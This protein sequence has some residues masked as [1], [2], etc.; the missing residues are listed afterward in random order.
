MEKI[1]VLF[2][3]LGNICRS[4]AA[5]GTFRHLVEEQGLADRFE[6]DS[7]GTGAYH[8]G[9]PPNANSRRAASRRGIQLGGRARQFKSRDFE[10]FEYIFT[11]DASNHRDVLALARSDA[12]R[13]QV[14]MFRQFDP[15]AA[16]AKTVPDV[17]DPYYGGEAG[18]DNVQ[19]IML[20]T[21]R[22]LLEWLLE[23][24]SARK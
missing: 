12:Q 5:E 3:C 16:G 13:E 2:V 1:R 6:I 15:N 22:D 8:T 24:G 23:N 18:F 21:S 17:P 4:P 7:A 20:A 9:E 19:D 11:M 14:R 10:K